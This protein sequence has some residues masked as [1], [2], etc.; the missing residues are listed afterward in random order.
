[1]TSRRSPLLSLAMAAAVVTSTA[2]GA[3]LLSIEEAQQLSQAT[4]RPILAMAG[5]KT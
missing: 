1:M 4:G 2:S 5:S 3:G